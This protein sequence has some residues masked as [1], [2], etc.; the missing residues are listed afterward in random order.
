IATIMVPDVLDYQQWK[1]GKRLEGFWQNC[2]AFVMTF[3]GL[4][5]SALMPLFMSFGGVG[6]GDNIDTALKN[7]DIMYGTFKSV[8]WLGIISSVICIIPII[9]YDLSEKKHSDYIRAL[10]IRAIVENYKNNE[11]SDEDIT[12][13]AEIIDF[14][15]KNNNQFVLDEL[16]SYAETELILNIK[17]QAVE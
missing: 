14:A 7:P 13:L 9:F 6:F 5:T 16:N 3:C 8:T 2:N 12:D 10:K 11:L 17:I 4:F 15:N 1:T